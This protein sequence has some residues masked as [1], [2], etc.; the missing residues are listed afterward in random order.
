MRALEYLRLLKYPGAKTTMIPDIEN[1]FHN[2]ELRRFIDVFG[3][4]GIILLNVTAPEK[5]YNDADREMFN[6]F[7]VLQ[8]HSQ[9]L[10]NNLYDSVQHG[11]LSRAQLKIRKKGKFHEEDDAE[12]GPDDLALKTLKRHMLGF[13]GM[14]NTY[15]TV[16]KSVHRYAMKTLEQFP[17][18]QREVKT[19]ILENLDFRDL[20]K[21]Y[22]S[23]GAFFYLDPPYFGK[24]WYN[25]NFKNEDYE[26]L[27]DLMKGMKGKY[28]MNI[29]AEQDE[30]ED[31]FGSPDFIK[32]YENQNQNAQT[33]GRPPR[34]KAFYTNV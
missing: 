15:N 26:D 7:R 12:L 22:D 10:Y 21:K 32:R 20:I 19:W 17:D 4:S 28:L 16:E 25:I 18:I 3:G 11:D 33:G 2:S 9:T 23:K 31:I 13:G 27:N 8:K 29:D 14:G 30:L 5:I 34:L 24:N 6:L 1:I